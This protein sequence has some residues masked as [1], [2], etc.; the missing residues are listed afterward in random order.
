MKPTVLITVNPLIIES[1]E[2][3]TMRKFISALDRRFDLYVLPINGYDFKR[4]RVRAYRRLSGGAFAD[5][6]MLTPAGDLW[7]IYS[8][9]FYLDQ[10]RFG[11]RLRRDYFKAQLDFHQTHLDAGRVRLMVNTPEADA[12][13]ALKSWLATLN[14]KET[15]VIPTYVCTHIDEVYDLQKHHGCLVVKPVWGGGSE[16]VDKLADEAS[17]SQFQRALQRR[18]TS[19]LGDF[20][21]QVCRTGDEKRLWFAGG[22]FVGG[23]RFR[24]CR[25][26]WADEWKF[27]LSTY[28]QNSRRTFSRDLAAARRLCEL[29]GVSVGSVDFIGDEINEIN[30]C[31]TVLT[32]FY[33]RKLFIDHRLAF[34][35]YFEQLLASL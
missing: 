20:C 32:N 16:G 5:A 4:G 22:E 30:G 27:R 8:D 24:G 6:G 29:S 15:R 33:H 10:R 26:P 12:R 3:S 23:R 28:D 31:G 25:T 13:A 7:I 9:G 2:F 14:F 11:F 19:D 34:I 1:R 17:V 21:F 18:R 35:N